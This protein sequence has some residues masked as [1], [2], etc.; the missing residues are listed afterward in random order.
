M[1]QRPPKKSGSQKTST[2]VAANEAAVAGW[3]QRIVGEMA[4]QKLSQRKL[5][6]LSNL[7]STSIRHIVNQADTIS[8]ETAKRIANALNVPIGYVT[9][10]IKGNVEGLESGTVKVL[11]VERPD[12]SK[13]DALDAGRAQVAVVAGGRMPPELRAL[14]VVDNSMNGTSLN[15]ATDPAMQLQKGDVIIWSPDLK[16]APG[17]LAVVRHQSQLLCRLLMETETGLHAVPLS[18]AFVRTSVKPADVMGSVLQIVKD[19]L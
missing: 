17:Q 10:G 12:G 6:Q 11:N 14:R 16:A 15:G 9:A 8:L 2:I 5:A 4:A 7:G 13:E 19:L 1:R 18:P 3:K